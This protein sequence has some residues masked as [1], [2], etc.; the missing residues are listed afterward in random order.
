MAYK[1]P[2]LA[3]RNQAVE[4]R[5]DITKGL[6]HV[7]VQKWSLNIFVEIHFELAQIEN[8]TCNDDDDDNGDRTSKATLKDGQPCQ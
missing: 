1:T 8:R 2:T 6:H 3:H 5:N 7:P 4:E